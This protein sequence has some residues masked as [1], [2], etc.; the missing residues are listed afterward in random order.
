MFERYCQDIK[1]VTRSGR[2]PSEV[3]VPML[4]LNLAQIIHQERQAEIERSLRV[5]RL[6]EC[7]PALRPAVNRPSTASTAR[8][9]PAG[10]A[11]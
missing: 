11:S 7:V 8:Q 10:A 4:Y 1:E 5:R 3:G 6:L 9:T 2:S